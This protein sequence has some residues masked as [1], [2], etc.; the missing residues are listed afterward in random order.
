MNSDDRMHCTGMAAPA[1]YMRSFKWNFVGHG[2]KFSKAEYQSG[3]LRG[4]VS[5]WLAL[6]KQLTQIPCLPFCG[7]FD[8]TQCPSEYRHILKWTSIMLDTIHCLRYGRLYFV[9]R[10]F[11]DLAILSPSR[12]WYRQLLFIFCA[13]VKQIMA[14]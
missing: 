11:R 1:V 5:P 3:Y 2:S 9:L 7:C 12:D 6:R 4:N 13:C 14:Q 10:A 8:Y